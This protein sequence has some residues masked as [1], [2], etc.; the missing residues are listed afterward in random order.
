MLTLTSNIELN[1]PGID[2]V[3][4][5]IE[6]AH[7]AG[8]R[9]VEMWMTFDRDVDAIKSALDATGMRLVSLVAEPRMNTAWPDA[10]V[11]VFL[12][13]LHRSVDNARTLGARFVILDPGLGFPGERREI[14]QQRLVDI[15]GTAAESIRDS[16]VT[17][18]ME[19]VNT[20]VDHPGLLVDRNIDVAAMVRAIDAPNLRMLF[21][22]YHSAAGGED[23][24]AEFAAAADLVDYV[25]VADSPG[26]GE[27]G[28]GAIDWVRIVDMLEVG[29]YS[30]SISLEF[31]PSTD[32]TSA[33]AYIRSVVE[34]RSALV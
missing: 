9:E 12:R 28:T 30:G 23:V 25:H 2:A 20:R 32:L 6:A 4:A 16:G 15:F 31:I 21:D 34:E 3:P 18:V 11:D 10:D 19:A 17:L 27:P 7:A 24:Q 5:R 29:G 8:F 33:I 1:Y 14:Q 26:R 22:I 13:G